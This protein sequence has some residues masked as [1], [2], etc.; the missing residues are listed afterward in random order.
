MATKQKT[1]PKAPKAN[2]SATRMS[3]AQSEV[4]RC[5]EDYWARRAELEAAVLLVK[6]AHSAL[7]D[8]RKGEEDLRRKFDE[9]KLALKQLLDVE[10]SPGSDIDSSHAPDKFN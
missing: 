3:E 2:T 1:K 5:W 4:Q 8:A 7:E 10:P 6:D 9:A